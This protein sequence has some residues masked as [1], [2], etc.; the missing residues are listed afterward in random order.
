MYIYPPGDYFRVG[1]YMEGVFRFK[2]GF[3]RP[4]AYTRWSLLSEFYRIRKTTRTQLHDLARTNTHA[5]NLLHPCATMQI[6]T[7]TV[8]SGFVMLGLISTV[9]SILPQAKSYKGE[10]R[11]LL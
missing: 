1:L 5:Y 4:G 7:A 11:E 8:D 10:F 3:K 6:T 2:V 9:Y